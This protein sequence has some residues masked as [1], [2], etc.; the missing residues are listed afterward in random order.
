MSSFVPWTI[1]KKGI[2]TTDI[3]AVGYVI[4][5]IIH[6]LI[7][8]SLGINLWLHGVINNISCIL[9]QGSIWEHNI[10]YKSIKDW[11]RFP[12]TDHIPRIILRATYDL[13]W[14]RILTIMGHKPFRTDAFDIALKI[15]SL[16]N[17][18][19]LLFGDIR[20]RLLL[21]NRV[22]GRRYRIA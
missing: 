16:R 13:S 10:L 5:N 4:K 17:S 12:D 20:I 11:F 1:N 7:L 2:M 8:L 3:M 6:Q 19:F 21:L 22:L 15:I 9:S 14:E 18:W